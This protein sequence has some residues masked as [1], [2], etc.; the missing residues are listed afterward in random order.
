MSF[1]A[2]AIALTAALSAFLSG[3]ILVNVNA[4][5]FGIASLIGY[6]LCVASV[7]VVIIALSVV[8]ALKSEEKEYEREH[9]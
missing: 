8:L 1:K 7:L 5:K 3:C 6:I 9:N 4:G 2:C